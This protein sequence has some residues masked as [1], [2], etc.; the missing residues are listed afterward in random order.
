MSPLLISMYIKCQLHSP[1]SQWRREAG[2]LPPHGR[3]HSF[4]ICHQNLA[5]LISACRCCRNSQEPARLQ[6]TDRMKYHTDDK[7]LQGQKTMLYSLHTVIFN[8][9]LQ[10]NDFFYWDLFTL[11]PNSW[12]TKED[13]SESSSLFSFYASTATSWV[14]YKLLSLSPF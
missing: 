5:A 13:F 9:V 1:W 14:E 6:I 7:P 11:T 12:S 10:Q 2:W 3:A 4:A 8:V